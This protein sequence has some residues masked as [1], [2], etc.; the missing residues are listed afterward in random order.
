[1]AYNFNKET[2]DKCGIT[3]AQ[4][5]KLPPMPTGIGHPEY[6][7]TKSFRLDYDGSVLCPECHKEKQLE[8]LFRLMDARDKKRKVQVAA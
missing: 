6:C 1:M 4:R 3:K 5:E 8:S 7:E 2:C